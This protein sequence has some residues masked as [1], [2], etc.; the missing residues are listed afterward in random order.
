[1]SRKIDYS[2]W[3]KMDFG[4]DDESSSSKEGNTR[5]PIVTRLHEPSKVTFSSQQGLKIEESHVQP[6]HQA[7]LVPTETIT[8]PKESMKKSANRLSMLTRNGSKYVDPKT[9]QVVYWSQDRK[10]VILSIVFDHTSI[11]SKYIVVETT[12]SLK[13]EDRYS[14]VGATSKGELIVKVITPEKSQI[15]LQG[16]LAYPYHLP[17]GEDNVDWEINATDAN[18]KLIRI[19]F[20]KAVPMQGLTV[21]WSRPL[22]HFSEIDVVSDI[23]GRADTNSSKTQ[24]KQDEWKQAWDEAHRLFKEKV[25]NREKDVILDISQGIH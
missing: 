18:M 16:Y 22:L 9:N 12:G 20:L 21:W 10:E 13:Y 15:L 3:D 5:Q 17:E 19:T 4:S 25:K 2:K 23:E 14:A 24:S 7:S 1:M 8:H 11:S 6:S